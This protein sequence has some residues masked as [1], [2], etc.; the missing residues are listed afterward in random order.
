MTRGER[1]DKLSRIE[2]TFAV[3]ES[4][5]KFGHGGKAR[6]RASG[7]GSSMQMIGEFQVFQNFILLNRLIPGAPLALLGDLPDSGADLRSISIQTP[8]T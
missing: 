5:W 8:H 1:N 2:N 3:D 7:F 4:Y 6:P